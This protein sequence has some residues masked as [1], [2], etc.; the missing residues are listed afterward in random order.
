M[1]APE[2]HNV[3]IYQAEPPRYPEWPPFGPSRAYPENPCDDKSDEGWVYDGVR[4]AFHLLGLDSAHFATP[5]WNPLGEVVRPGDRVVI[6][7]NLVL[8]YN[9]S[10]ETTQCLITHASVVRPIIDYAYLALQ[11]RGSV[12]VADCP[13]GNADFSRIK[14]ESG[15]GELETF[16]QGQGRDFRVLDLRKYEYGHGPR[17]FLEARKLIDGDPE[18][19]AEVDLGRQSAFVDLPYIENLYGADYDRREIRA[20]HNR[21]TNKYLI[22]KTFLKADVVIH[23]PKLKT[24][25]KL[26]TTLNLKG[27]VGINGDKNYLPHYRIGDAPHHGDEFP[28]VDS[29]MQWMK[30]RSR[31]FLYDHLLGSDFRKRTGTHKALQALYRGFSSG[32][33]EKGSNGQSITSGNW[34]GNETVYRTVYDLARVLFH[35]DRDGR[36]C[37]EPQRRFFSVVDGVIGGEREGPLNP[38][39]KPCGA[40]IAGLDPVAVD[41]VATRLMGLD[42]ERMVV[43]TRLK[44]L[45]PAHALRHPGYD[46]IRTASNRSEWC[47]DI[48]AGRDPHLSFV[49]HHGWRNYLEVQ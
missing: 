39:P 32:R 40:F 27:L 24:H 12:T 38:S 2:R 48:F 29:R 17:G 19:Y 25:K 13:H 7:P 41:L 42:P 33:R 34:Y 3:A 14:S 22:A 35:A 18:G 8:D 36:L 9:G 21:E 46:A 23:V 43:F 31:R 20:T 49:P 10:G 37:S 47:G 15:L 45:P 44:D 5:Q 30:R 4:E 6:K 16:Y 28:P 1:D 11:G 26:G